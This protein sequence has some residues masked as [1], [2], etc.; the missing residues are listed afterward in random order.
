MQLSLGSPLHTH[1]HFQRSINLGLRHLSRR[2][3]F[4]ADMQAHHA[5]ALA[6]LIGFACTRAGLRRVAGVAACE[7]RL[8][9]PSC[10]WARG[11][12]GRPATG[13]VL[14]QL[15][16]PPCVRPQAAAAAAWSRMRSRAGARLRFLYVL[17][18][19][20]AMPPPW[21]S[22]MRSCCA[23]PSMLWSMKCFACP[24][25]PAWDWATTLPQVHTEPCTGTGTT[26]TCWH[27]CLHAPACPHSIQCLPGRARDTHRLM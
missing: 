11:R 14:L 2:P 17:G 10:A 20:N 21:L 12:L 25:M 9:R 6:A 24:I 4:H 19:S 3:K 16:L 23:C 1:R 5:V 7:P 15:L 18:P 26:S 13:S 8:A 27:A 22:R